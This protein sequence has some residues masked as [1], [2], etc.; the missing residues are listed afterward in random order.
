MIATSKTHFLFQGS[1]YD[2]IDGVAMGS[3]LAP[4]L[5]NLFLGRHEKE[6]IYWYNILV[7]KTH[8]IVDM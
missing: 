5:S 1:L 2:Q 7:T 6:W 8:I 3:P 4:I